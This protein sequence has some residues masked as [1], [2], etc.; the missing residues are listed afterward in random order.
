MPSQKESFGVKKK[1][2]PMFS[3]YDDKEVNKMAEMAKSFK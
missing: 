1:K 3:V 2:L